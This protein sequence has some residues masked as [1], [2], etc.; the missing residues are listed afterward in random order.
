MSQG[1]D[2]SGDRERRAHWGRVL[3][4]A[5]LIVVAVALIIIGVGA[6]RYTRVQA[7]RLSVKDV[8]P[9]SVRLSGATPPMAWPKTGEAAVEVEGLGSLG[10]SG[11]ETPVPI[12]SLAKVMTAYV[13]LRAHPMSVG[14]S[15]FTATVTADDWS[16]YNS[17]Y[18]QGESV[19][20]VRPGETLTERQALEALLIPSGNNIATLLA[21]YDAGSEAVFVDRMNAMAHQL[22]MD[23]TTY[24]DASGFSS[25]TVSTPSDQLKLAAAAMQ[26]PAFAQIVDM[27]SAVLPVEGKVYNYDT[28]AGQQGF[29]GIKTGSD[30]SAG[31]CF[32]FAKRATAQ[33]KTLTVLGAVF[34][35]DRTAPTYPMINAAL[36]AS[37]AL[38]SS[39]VAA[40]REE[41]IL[42]AGT[43]VAVITNA[44]G[45]HVR[46]TTSQA[47]TGLGWGGMQENVSVSLA[48][49][50][51]TLANGQQ[52]ATVTV[53]KGAPA[54]FG[55][56][57]TVALARST[58]PKLT[59]HWRLRHVLPKPL[60]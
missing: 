21:N 4:N 56:G 30:G 18:L 13:I 59:W 5:L 20:T 29:L 15:G 36:T 54:G 51:A 22:G 55:G 45:K 42:P 52:V 44:Q 28:L 31:G 3:R 47:I 40:V 9:A 49:V 38:A 2:W 39:A 43:R 24:V 26:L 23:H 32:L 57:S 60:R 8:L 27:G 19:V 58:M 34:G 37:Q 50:G 48:K 16:V 25:K 7:P 41:T 17:D 1:I 6:W 35:Q 33:G 53:N 14:G 46:A 10:T 12:A 11:G